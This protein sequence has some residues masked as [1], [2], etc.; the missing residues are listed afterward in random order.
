MIKLGIEPSHV[1]ATLNHY[2]GHRAG[3]AGVYNQSSYGPQI[4]RA[5]ALWAEHVTSLVEGRAA[6]VVQMRATQ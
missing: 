1:E 5:L 4:K 3:I 2:S 6:K